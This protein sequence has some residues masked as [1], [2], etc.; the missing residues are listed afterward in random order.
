MSLT[1][2]VPDEWDDSEDEQDK[3]E[4]KSETEDGNYYLYSAENII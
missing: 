2:M 3:S 4:S 1:L